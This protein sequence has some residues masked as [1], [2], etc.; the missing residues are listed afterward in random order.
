[1]LRPVQLP[2]PNL[3]GLS[4]DR[5]EVN[6]SGGNGFVNA[7]SRH[8]TLFKLAT[9]LVQTPA[10]PTTCL[11]D[12]SKWFGR[13]ENL[14][15]VPE[16]DATG[17]VKDAPEHTLRS[18]ADG[19]PSDSPQ[20][21]LIVLPPLGPHVCSHLQHLHEVPGS[22]TPRFS[23]LESNRPAPI[24]P[25]TMVPRYISHIDEFPGPLRYGL[26]DGKGKP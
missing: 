23:L 25:S 8:S 24:E 21:T 9:G 7:S 3:S 4:S 20:R 10:I 14:P 19:P 17:P 11:A 13:L 1:M 18:P 5:E 16:L 15:R 26:D 12:L 6:R 2:R 22:L